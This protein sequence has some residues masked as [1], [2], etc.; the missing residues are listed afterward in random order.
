L[1]FILGSSHGTGGKKKGEGWGR[2]Y[3]G[4]MNKKKNCREILVSFFW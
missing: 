3:G 4:E 2:G 1:K